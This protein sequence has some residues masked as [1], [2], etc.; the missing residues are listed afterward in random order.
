MKQKNQKKSSIVHLTPWFSQKIVYRQAAESQID[1][2][3][4]SDINSRIITAEGAKVAKK[5]L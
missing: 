5:F 3:A 4:V 1:S 2:S